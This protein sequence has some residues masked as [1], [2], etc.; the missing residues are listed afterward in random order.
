M[1]TLH[2]PAAG[3][4]PESSCWCLDLGRM[5]YERV[6]RLQRR[7]VEFKCRRAMDRDLLLLV[8]HPPVYTL[9]NRRSKSHCPEAQSNAF[10][11]GIPVI[12]TERGGDITYH[13]PGQLVAYPI[14]DL[15]G[16]GLGVKNLVYRLEQA[17][18]DTAATFGVEAAR[19]KLNPGVWVNGDKLGS[20]GL[21][22]RRGISFHGLALNVN[23]DLAPFSWIDPCGLA[24]VSMTSLELAG[25]KAADLELAKQA[26]L[27]SFK[28]VFSCG[29]APAELRSL[30][31]SFETEHELQQ[32]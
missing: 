19:N 13:G 31:S 8:E 22:V 32:A 3:K 16:S 30:L 6:R 11:H 26:M 4:S 18:I 25:A 1:D 15:K 17:M 2:N 9:G 29:F 14:F 27:D 12:S 10:L 23:N 21:A 5:E 20:I 28:G 24:N 7:F